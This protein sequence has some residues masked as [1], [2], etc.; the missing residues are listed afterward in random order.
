MSHSL[1]E[2]ALH[3]ASARGWHVFPLLPGDKAPAGHLV[4]RGHLDATTDPATIRQW[5]GILPHANIGISLEPSGLVALD[6]DTNGGKP[7]LESLSVIAH[8]LPDTLSATTGR[9]GFHVV[10]SRPPGIEPK[11]RI[12]FKPGLD[13]LGKGYI[14]AAPSTLS[15]GGGYRWNNEL[16]IVELPPVLV[17]EFEDQKTLVASLGDSGNGG[18][19][20]TIVEGGRND[21]L[22]RLGCALRDQGIGERALIYALAAENQER[23][24]P[25]LD[26]NEV[27]LVASSVMVRVA[28]SRDVAANEIFSAAMEVESTQQAIENAAPG[29]AVLLSDLALRP[30]PPIRTYSTGMPHL[31]A[32][33]GGGFSTRQLCIVSA[34]PAD[35]KSAFVVDRAL[36]IEKEI[37][38]LHISTELESDEMLA[39]YG[40]NLIGCPWTAIVRGSVSAEMVSQ[41]VEG[42]R[43]RVIGCEVLPRDG[44]EALRAIAIEIQGMIAEYGVPPLVIVDYL[45]D[46]AR[47]AKEQ[48]VKT[49]VGDIATTLRAL[50]QHFD[51]AMVVVS[52]VSRSYY[53]AAK[54]AAMRQSTDP[55]VYLAAAKESGDVDYA[56]A[57]VLFLDVDVADDKGTRPAR[58][59]VAK[60]RHGNPAFAGARFDGAP[61][62]WVAAPEALVEMKMESRSTKQ[63]DETNSADDVAMVE[64]VTRAFGQGK[65]YSKTEWAETIKPLPEKRTA[66]AIGRLVLAGRLEIQDGSY[67]D[68][69]KT[70]RAKQVIGV[71][72]N[73]PPLTKSPS[74]GKT[75]TLSEIMAQSG[76][77]E[78][79]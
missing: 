33:I 16:P 9:G 11:R 31:D 47:G 15:S 21:A 44:Q 51:C 36:V 66:A 70:I 72:K 5:W 60:A 63:A 20:S 14:V 39:R 34:P 25:P 10:Y 18:A 13:L 23:F 35:G 79:P 74:E 65:A 37:P 8:E 59:A 22:F 68:R 17:R 62:R 32:L 75:P 67:I 12:G 73:A 4:S 52:S 49:R 48:D 3:Y 54:Q 28:P 53:G 56:A 43:V 76:E 29:L 26:D 19:L 64:A 24:K 42:K 2:T 6:V 58:I 55:R 61:G 50:A 45:Q 69:H 1:L 78:S 38:V 77:K 41:R 30:K 57:T 27:L 71:P 40:A 7:G 46:L